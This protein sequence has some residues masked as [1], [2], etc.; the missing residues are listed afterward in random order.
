[1][2][3]KKKET[4][5]LHEKKPRWPFKIVVFI[6]LRIQSDIIVVVVDD[7]DDDGFNGIIISY[8]YEYIFFFVFSIGTCS[9]NKK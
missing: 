9:L 7:D 1:V 8:Y 4:S 2:L 5:A 6:I 3:D